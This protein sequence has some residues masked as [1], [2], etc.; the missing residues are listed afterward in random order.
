M[1]SSKLQWMHF[2]FGMLTLSSIRP[3]QT[4]DLRARKVSGRHQITEDGRHLVDGVAF[5]RALL[6]KPSRPL[7]HIPPRKRRRLLTNE[8][9]DDSLLPQSLNQQIALRTQ[10]DDLLDTNFEDGEASDEEQDSDFLDEDELGDEVQDIQDDQ[11]NGLGIILNADG[12]PYEGSE[13]DQNSEDH[14]SFPQRITDGALRPA[15]RRLLKA[16]ELSRNTTSSNEEVPTDLDV[17]ARRASAGSNKS[18]RFED[19]EQDV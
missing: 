5:G 8:E 11:G 2:A 13:G 7:I 18:V 10:S 16:R 15:R 9:D 12:T 6:R 4:P 3:L 17:G 19:E 1:K 14:G